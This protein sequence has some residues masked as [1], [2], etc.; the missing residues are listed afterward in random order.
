[1]KLNK[2]YPE[3]QPTLTRFLGDG[4]SITPWD[5]YRRV[6]GA[7]MVCLCARK[8]SVA[9]CHRRASRSSVSD[10]STISSSSIAETWQ[11]IP[12][13]RQHK[14]TAKTGLGLSRKLKYRRDSMEHVTA[15]AS[16]KSFISKYQINSSSERY[17]TNSLDSRYFS[18]LRGTVS[19]YARP[20][21]RQY[22]F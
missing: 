3:G 9:R 2:H 22:H 8:S 17:C 1:M 20:R 5:R 13:G 16:T 7:A 15:N 21:V 10:V 4:V 11:S 18:V 19:F 6:A 14:R 12:E